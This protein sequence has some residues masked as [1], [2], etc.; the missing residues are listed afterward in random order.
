[1]QVKEFDRDV[2]I[3]AAPDSAPEL[4][5]LSGA[6]FSKLMNSEKVATEYALLQDK[7]PCL[8][9]SFDKINPCSIGQFIYLYEVTTSITALLFNINAYD[10]PA[11]ELGKEATFALMERADFEEL[12]SKIQPIVEIDGKFIA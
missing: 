2:T 8:T 4:G 5:Y 10:Q 12:A 7:R 3:A 1:M 9:V 11:V 6:K